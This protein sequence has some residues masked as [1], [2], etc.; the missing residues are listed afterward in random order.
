L[1]LLQE[2]N[3]VGDLTKVL[4]AI[5]TIGLVAT[6]VVNGPNT[7]K[8]VTAASGGFANSITAA[9]KG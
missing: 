8:V 9:E 2:V 5:T 6:L 1:L 3:K 4:L 7:A